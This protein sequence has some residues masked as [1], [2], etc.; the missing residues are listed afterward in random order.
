MTGQIVL[1]E[2]L[3]RPPVHGLIRRRLVDPLCKLPAGS[4]GL[5]VAPAGA[6]KTTL[7]AWVA[8]RCGIPVGWY[9]AAS[10]DRAEAGLV[11][12]LAHTLMPVT[13]VEA[14]DVETMADLLGRL[15][16]WRG[17]SA[18]LILDD[19]HE[20]E[21]SEAST[22]LA[23]FVALRPGRLRVLMGSRRPPDLNVPRLRVSGTVREIDGDDLRFRHWEVEELFAKIFREPIAPKSAAALTRRTGGWAAGLTLFRLATTGRTPAGREHAVEELGGRSKLI[24][25]YLTRNV[26]AELPEKTRRFMLTTAT[27]GRLTGPLCDGLLGETGSG[28]VLDLLERRQLFTTCDDDGA[29]YRYHEVLR[30]HL[31][32]ELVEEYG[33]AQARA[34]YARSAG[35]LEAAQHHRD[36]AIA[37][38]KAGN[39]VAV[40]RLVHESAE[41]ASA[42]GDLPFPPHM[43]REDP[44]LAMAEARRLGRTGALAEAG[45]AYRR[46]QDLCD[47][48]EYQTVCRRER[49]LV[50]LWRPGG[51]GVR[52]GGSEHWS[53]P[54][55]S[56]L[57]TTPSDAQGGSR[58]EGAHARLIEGLVAVSM[59]DLVG[60]RK[61]LAESAEQ[62]SDPV[63][64]LFARLA[65][66]VVDIVFGAPGDPTDRLGEI[67]L[68]AE[69][70]GFPWLAR[71][72]RGLHEAALAVSAHWRLAACDELV[73]ECVHSGDRWGAAI[74]RMST[75]LVRSRHRDE[76][77][78]NDFTDAGELFAQAGAEVGEV[79]AQV[80]AC[81][82]ARERE[83]HS[84][85][86]AQLAGRCRALRVRGAHAVATLAREQEGQGAGAVPTSAEVDARRTLE[87]LG[88]AELLG[89]GATSV[90]AGTPTLSRVAVRCFGGFGFEVGGRPVDMSRIRPKAAA[91][92]HILAL[93]SGRHVHREVLEEALWPGVVHEVA[94]HR[95]QVAVSSIRS[96]LGSTGVSIR[97]RG[98]AYGLHL[99]RGTVSDV[100]AF[101][102]VLAGASGIGP[103]GIV[104]RVRMRRE[105]LELYRGDL[106]P[107]DGPAEFVTEIRDR[108][109]RAAAEAAAALAEDCRA[110]GDGD[111]AREAARMSVRLNPYQ[112]RPWELLI[113]LD[114]ATG[115]RCA[116]DQTRREYSRARAEVAGR[117]VTNP[118]RRPPPGAARAP[119]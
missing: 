32:S 69:L 52:T 65:G 58:T 99:P 41:V 70:A 14:G 36:A 88:L 15:D 40:G 26:L 104:D 98:E 39:W 49:A 17:P 27:L 33:I 63:A 85:A 24:R 108:L 28:R 12:H 95:L 21:A 7:L 90:R 29:T 79:W 75:A 117:A 57:R 55:R 77:A 31:E 114:E 5:V 101:E 53:A 92:L 72:C 73:R 102:E 91:L 66:S 82:E 64:S 16:G 56:A 50:E 116:A 4:L 68:D 78:H 111:D 54:V 3:R 112:D 46:A 83:G 80:F 76:Q 81:L 20:I 6:G 84:G 105:A 109:R 19:V 96:L 42:L 2:K 115:D 97:R 113:A 94:C 51:G 30:T 38:A 67:S 34:W 86:L 71:L 119:E 10:D 100:S 18:L 25:S 43:L 9:R 8:D 61:S 89:E 106:L 23:R 110:L 118:D 107:E 47:D 13:G 11:A 44:W 60:A 93:H 1:R 37:H 74:L 22:S 59:G 48:P 103:D 87:V 62:E 35:L 45:N